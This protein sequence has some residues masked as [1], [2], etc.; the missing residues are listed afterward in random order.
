M[1]GL[2]EEEIFTIWLDDSGRY[3]SDVIYLCGELDASTVPS[4]LADIKSILKRNRS[5][6]FDVHLLSYTDSTGLAAILSINNTLKRE[7]KRAYLVG[8]HGVLAKIL[9]ITHINEELECL[10]D[11]ESAI[12]KIKAER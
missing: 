2:G 8:C 12:A 11:I 9:D 1:G 6:I 3:D 4:F 10:D 5:V 7:N